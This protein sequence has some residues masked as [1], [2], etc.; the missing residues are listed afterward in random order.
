LYTTLSPCCGVT[1]ILWARPRRRC[2]RRSPMPGWMRS[3][4]RDLGEDRVASHNHYSGKQICR[5]GQEE[6]GTP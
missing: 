1:R 5:D 2:T 4:V 6:A 3:L